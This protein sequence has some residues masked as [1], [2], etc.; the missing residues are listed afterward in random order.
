MYNGYMGHRDTALQSHYD[1]Y[2][3]VAQGVIRAAKARKPRGYFGSYG[4]CYVPEV[5]RAAL[6]ELDAAF[7][8]LE[9]DHGFWSEYDEVLCNYVSRPTPLYYAAGV[10]DHVRGGQD[11]RHGARVFVKLEGFAHTGAHKINNALGQVLL[12]KRLGKTRIIAETGA[13]QHGLATATA[14]AKLGLACRIYMGAVDVRRQRPN[15]HIMRMLGAEL[16]AVESGQ[17]TL[18]DAINEAMRDWATNFAST[19]YVIG[20]ALGPAPF[21][22]MVQCFQSVIGAELVAQCK[23]R[24][25]R[26]SA[27]VSCVGGGSNAM[28]ICTPFLREIRQYVQTHDF[29]PSLHIAEAGGRGRRIG[30]HATRLAC[31]E[32]MQE[33][34][35]EGVVQGYR[36]RFISNSDGQLAHTYSI[37]AGLDYP[38]VGPHL[39]HLVER[40]ELH[41]SSTTDAEALE[42]LR[43]FARK[44]GIVF[45]LES[46][47]AVAPALKLAASMGRDETVFIHM[48]GRGDK[49]LFITAPERD[50]EAWKEFLRSELERLSDVSSSQCAS[51]VKGE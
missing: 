1:M 9:D 41:P 14:C 50:S 49:D 43:L 15:V 38:G 7:F 31:D 51:S 13:G 46:A 26:P 37:S 42:G 34:V 17:Q 40:G 23:A 21:P 8:A 6:M 45:A 16:V 25:L 44:E 35:R 28:G 36:S 22:D 18:K 39:A 47:H 2:L 33:S 5:L 20:S 30:E 29:S 27:I 10:T 4:G 32:E 19:H 24:G 11:E 48:S 12:A 3:P